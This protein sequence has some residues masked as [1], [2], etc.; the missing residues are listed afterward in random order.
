MKETYL[1]ITEEC[2]AIDELCVICL[3]IEDGLK[4]RT[5]VHSK[6]LNS[7]CHCHY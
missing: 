1:N 4:N 2:D 5:I 3:E 6:F 7:R